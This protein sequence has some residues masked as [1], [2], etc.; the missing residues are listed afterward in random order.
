M[1]KF[2]EKTGNEKIDTL[3]NEILDLI[4]G[5]LDIDLPV[6]E[7]DRDLYVKITNRISKIKNVLEGGD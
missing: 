3:T 2:E 6:N 1:E 5:R 4:A 7:K